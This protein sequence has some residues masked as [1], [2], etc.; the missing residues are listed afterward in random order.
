MDRVGSG[1]GVS[2][3][4]KARPPSS[5]GKHK[6]GSLENS[7]GSGSDGDSRAAEEEGKGGRSHAHRGD[8]E[9]PLKRYDSECECVCVCVCVKRGWFGKSLVFVC[10]G[11]NFL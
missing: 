10:I 7:G 9:A 8:L 11:F 3:V 1:G 4:P 5:L 6:S 2:G